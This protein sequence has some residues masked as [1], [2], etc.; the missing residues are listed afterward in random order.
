MIEVPDPEIGPFF[1]IFKTLEAESWQ[2]L[3]PDEILDEYTVLIPTGGN[4]LD[5]ILELTSSA[6]TIAD[7]SDSAL[8]PGTYYI[9]LL[10]THY[11]GQQSN[12]QITLSIMDAISLPSFD[13]NPTEEA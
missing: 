5:G 12:Q 11:T 9:D 10:W 8:D 2:S 4:S 3:I 1:V 7:L 13:L 6:L